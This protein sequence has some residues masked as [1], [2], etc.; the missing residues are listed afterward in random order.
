MSIEHETFQDGGLKYTLLKLKDRLTALLAGKVDADAQATSSTLGLVKLNP[1]QSIDVNADGQLTV[2]G[3]LGQYPT[4]T[5]IYAPNNRD[6]R[7]VAD[8]A[9]LMTDALGMDMSANRSMAIVSGYGMTCKSAA[10]GATEYHVTNNYANRIICKACEEGYAALDE[11]TSTV[12]RIVPVVSV[13]IKGAAY[14]P[15]SSAN[16][17]AAANDI[18][19]TVEETLNPNAATTTIRLFGKMQSYATMHMG[20]GVRSGGGGRSLVIGGGVSKTGSTND[21][22]LIGNGIY[23]SGNGVAAFGRHHIIPKNRAFAAGTGHD[24]TKAKSEAVSAVGQ[25]SSLDSNTLFAVGN[26]TSHTARLNAFEVV[27]DGFIIRSPGGT[28]YKVAVDDSGNLTTT[29]V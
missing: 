26:G 2:G 3:R 20:N 11:A 9:F 24:F 27:A 28:R 23:S 17:S 21:N 15:D 8:Y 19:I 13:Q 6:P 7:N 29:A 16:S 14:T 1:N 4:T 5:G 12:Q 10:A 25:Y 18:V 22:C